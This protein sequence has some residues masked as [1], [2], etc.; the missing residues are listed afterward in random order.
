MLYELL[1]FGPFRDE[2]QG[3]YLCPSKP[4]QRRNVLSRNFVDFRSEKLNVGTEDRE[5]LR[6]WSI[7]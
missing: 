5:E 2:L 6:H 3:H 4:V 7:G 1:H